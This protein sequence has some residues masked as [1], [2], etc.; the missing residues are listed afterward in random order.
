MQKCRYARR[1]SEKHEF[2][3][4]MVIFWFPDVG[5]PSEIRV[6]KMVS[7]WHRFFKI[8]GSFWEAFWHQKAIQ[9]RLEKTGWFTYDFGDPGGG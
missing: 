2:E 5:K 9:K 6:G 1:L 4:P 8:L 3:G 7:F